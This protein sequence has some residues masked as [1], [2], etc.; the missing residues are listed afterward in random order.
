MPASGDDNKGGQITVTKEVYPSDAPWPEYF[1]IEVTG[2]D[3]SKSKD[4][5]ADNK[6]QTWDGLW[7]GW[8][9]ILEAVED[10]AGPNW[11]TEDL[12]IT[13]Y[14]Y[15]DSNYDFTITNTF[16]GEEEEEEEEEEEYSITVTKKVGR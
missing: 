9:T 8:Y 13:V 4:F 7:E 10:N 14:V 5:T 3:Y 15:S 11:S 2:P 12:P 1:G 16:E 6:T